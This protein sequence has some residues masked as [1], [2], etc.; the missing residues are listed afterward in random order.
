MR[1]STTTAQQQ[2]QQQQ[3]Q[4][5][6]Q[7]G[8]DKI[9]IAK[10]ITIPKICFSYIK[11][12]PDKSLSTSF[13]FELF[14]ISIKASIYSGFY[15]LLFLSLFILEFISSMIP[16]IYNFVIYLNHCCTFHSFHLQKI[17]NF[18]DILFY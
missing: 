15:L 13:P 8:I 1:D 7:P 4:H 18:L 14:I 2:L 9:A 10:N 3:K 12:L 5:T 11:A 6:I 17:L 16:V